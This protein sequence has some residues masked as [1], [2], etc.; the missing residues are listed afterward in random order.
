MKINKE[1]IKAIAVKIYNTLIKLY[2][3]VKGVIA[4]WKRKK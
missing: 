2:P 3:A 1:K 4:I